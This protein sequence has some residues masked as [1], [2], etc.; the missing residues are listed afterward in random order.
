MTF[1]RILVGWDGSGPA[2]AALRIATA[3]AD[4]VGGEV[5]A[6]AVFNKPTDSPTIDGAQVVDPE[7]RGVREHYAERFDGGSVRF[8]AIVDSAS[9]AYALARFAHDHDFDLIAVGR[10]TGG[11]SRDGD[12]TLH[13][14]VAHAAVPLLVVGAE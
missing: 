11:K 12:R 9:P 10:S 4:E 2:D 3:Y 13:E 8:H 1:R 14:L 5:E 7:R 6:L